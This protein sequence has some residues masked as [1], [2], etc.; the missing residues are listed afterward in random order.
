MLPVLG[1]WRGSGDTHIV[2]EA[3]DAHVVFTVWAVA[4]VRVGR[5]TGELA[6]GVGV[7]GERHAVGLHPLTLTDRRLSSTHHQ[8]H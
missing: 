2:R 5:L 8:L 7:L 4:V 1:P 3:G 6:Q